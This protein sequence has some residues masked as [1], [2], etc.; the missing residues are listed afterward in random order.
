MESTPDPELI[1]R[2]LNFHGQPLQKLW[3]ADLNTLSLELQDPDFEVYQQ[4][5]KHLSFQDRGKRQKLQQFIVKKASALF[6]SS[7]KNTGVKEKI[8]SDEVSEAGRLYH[9]FHH[10]KVSLGLVAQGRKLGGKGL[11]SYQGEAGRKEGSSS[12]RGEFGRKGG[13][14]SYCGEPG[15]E[16]GLASYCGE[17]GREEG[18]VS[19]RGKPG[20][21]EGLTSYGGK[22]SR[23]EGSAS[24]CGERG[25]KEGLVCY[26]GKPGGF[27]VL[28]L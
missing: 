11:A 14:A 15:R 20:R 4:R 2:S 3:E 7:M 25:K 21:E 24:Y 8:T 27:G 18:L 28:S 16:E 17:L 23:E 12:Y 9:W 10:H 26:C 6:D 5:Q 19:Y 22:P 13:L 1:T